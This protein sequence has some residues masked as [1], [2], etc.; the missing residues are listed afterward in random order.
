MTP[1]REPTVVGLDSAEHSGVAVLDGPRLVKAGVFRTRTPDDVARACDAFLIF[2][3]TLVVIEDCYLKANDHTGIM[4][5]RLTGQWIQEISRRG[6]SCSLVLASTWQPAVL[7][8]SARAK[9]AERKAMAVAWAL[10][11]FGKVLR[12]DAADAAGIAWWGYKRLLGTGTPA[13]AETP[14][15]AHL[16]HSGT[17]SGAGV[18]AR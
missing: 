8:C 18:P 3:P 2:R 9:R 5:A 17:A 1:T 12:E 11:T 10:K 16:T 15:H 14:R 4:L 7:G 13:G 6:F